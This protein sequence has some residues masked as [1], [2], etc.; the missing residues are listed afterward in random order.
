MWIRAYLAAYFLVVTAALLGSWQARILERL[1]AA[2][3]GAAFLAALGLGALL[4][5]VSR[6]PA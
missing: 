3:V 1:P 4:A 6:R 2:Y 5:A